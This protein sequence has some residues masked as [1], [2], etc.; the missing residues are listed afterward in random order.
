MRHFFVSLFIV[1]CSLSVFAAAKNS[2]QNMKNALDAVAPY[3]LQNE[4][5]TIAQKTWAIHETGPDWSFYIYDGQKGNS[6]ILLTKDLK[7]IQRVFC[8]QENAPPPCEL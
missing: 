1:V 6:V 2:I 8:P 4:Q 3:L 7:F 5:V